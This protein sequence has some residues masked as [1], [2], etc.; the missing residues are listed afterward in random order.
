M[1]LF[2]ADGDRK[3]GP[4]G[5]NQFQTLVKTKRINAKTL[6]WQVGMS[7]WE[8]LGTFLGRSVHAQ[9]A[10]RSL[11]QSGN[12]AIC[13]ECRNLYEREDL[14]QIQDYWVCGGCKPVFIQ[15]IKEGV[16]P[17]S[18]ATYKNYG[19][20]E[21]GLKGEYDVAV[22]DIIREA[23]H[24]TYGS[25]A[26]IVGSLFLVWVIT[27]LIQNI[28]FI[29]LP[30][31]VWLS[32]LFIDQ[33]AGSTGS[34]FLMMTIIILSI[35][36]M[37]A[38]SLMVQA[39]LWIGLE[40][41]GV[42]RSVDLPISPRYVFD[43]FRQFFTLAL[44]CLVAMVCV[45]LGFLL[46]ILPGIYLAIGS[47]LALQLVVDKKLGPWDAFKV[48]VRAISR[49]WFKVFLLLTVLMGIFFISVIPLGIGLIWSWPLFINAK[50]ILYRNIFGIEHT[51]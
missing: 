47:F 39:P 51:M 8:E 2:Y 6:V 35:V 37:M 10:A 49:K 42:R 36:I 12:F 27:S 26:V 18:G 32:T 14:I 13:S 45:S 23:W 40:M 41:L 3:V 16:R 20:L 44:T 28:L 25:K 22:F 19:S 38:L 4:I 5:I 29:P 1:E 43:Y 9:N 15:K 11:V 21:K 17:R 34:A 48:S 31:V 50:G 33:A 46:L 30:F 7:Q 24:L